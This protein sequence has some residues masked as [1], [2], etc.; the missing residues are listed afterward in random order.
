[1]RFDKFKLRFDRNVSVQKKAAVRRAVMFGMKSFQ[2]FE[3]QRGNKE[4][5]AQRNAYGKPDEKMKNAL[6]YDQSVDFP[7][8]KAY[9]LHGRVFA[10]A[11]NQ[12]HVQ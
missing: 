10:I 11:L 7:V 6:F 2:L 5:P 12:Y 1:M 4:L 9:D 8:I 3:R